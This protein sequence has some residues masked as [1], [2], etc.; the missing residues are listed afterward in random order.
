[1]E[2]MKGIRLARL[3]VLAVTLLAAASCARF[4]DIKVNSCSLGSVSL[5]GFTAADAVLDMEIDNP[6]MAFTIS[7][8]DGAVIHAQAD[9]AIFLKGGPV[10]IERKCVK[11]Y[12]VPVTATLGPA[13][14]IMELAG[15]VSGGDYSGY[16]LDITLTVSL[17]G[18][19]SRKVKLDPMPINDLLNENQG[20]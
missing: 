13:M 9:T 1:M 18:G 10:D 3:L 19:I 7:D 20:L 5:R 14:S 15:V 12:Q 17:N 8:I 11:T 4:Q 2:K 6:T 16:D